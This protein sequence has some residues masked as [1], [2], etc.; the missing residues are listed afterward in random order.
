MD[1]G[2]IGVWTFAFDGQPAGEVREAAAELDELGYGAIWFAE[3]T[4]REALTQASLLLHATNR[5]TVATGIARTVG[6]DPAVM[7]L[8]HHTLTEAFPERFLLGLGGH[9]SPK[10]E[11]GITG[12]GD[13]RPIDTMRDY[14][15]AMDAV[16][17]FSV[18]PRRA[19]A[20]LGPQALKL[21]AEKTWGAHTYFV[22]VEHT[23]QA[24]E[25]LGPEALLAVELPVVLGH[26]REV[27]RARVGG[28]FRARHYANNLRRLGFT[29]DDLAGSDRL[30]DALVV[31]GDVDAVAKRI[32]EHLDAGANHVCVE[33]LTADSQRLPRA[34]WRELASLV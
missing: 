16:P 15:D 12:A 2:S 1:L 19:L 11:P 7:A 3:S 23:A 20:A 17:G 27:A 32:Q 29:E 14:L 5:L 4:G 21:A 30:V 13:P 31:T 24:R 10:Q 9:R 22:P 25:I 34:E 18:R 28:G 33:V 6:R 26:D 8:A